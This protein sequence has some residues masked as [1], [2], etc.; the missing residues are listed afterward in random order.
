M[1]E[2]RLSAIVQT[3]RLAVF[4]PD[5]RGRLC[6]VGRAPDW[7]LALWPDVPAGG[8]V[9]HEATS[10]FLENFLVDARAGWGTP[11]GLRLRSGPWVEKDA[12]DREYSLQATSL[13]V[14]GHPT[15]LIEE[16]AAAYEERTIALQKVHEVSLAFEKLQRAEQALAEEK[17]RL[18]E[19]VE[20]RTRELSQ[21]NFALREEIAV[22]RRYADRLLGVREIYRAILAAQSPAAIAEA[23]LLRL[24]PLLPCEQ[25]S[26]VAMEPET[27][28]A[29]ILARI[30][31]GA[32]TKGEGWQ[33]S[34]AQLEG[35]RVL[36]SGRLQRISG[37]ANLFDAFT[38]EKSAAGEVWPLMIDVPL[39][40]ED[41]LVG[42]LNL[43]TRT[44]A[45]F[46]AEHEEIATEVA[47]LLAV[48][49]RQARLF[50]ALSAG[51][52]RLRALS[53][54]LVDV[55]ETERRFM[56]H[57][58]HDEIGQLLTGLK[59]TLELPG[60]E[61]SQAPDPSVRDAI[62]LVDELIGRVRRLSL[63]L[64]P[65]VLDDLGLLSA[66]DWLFKRVRGQTGIEVRF[67]HSLAPGRLPSRLE[68]AAF[69]IV[70]EAL[71]NIA[72]H[73]GVKEATVRVWVDGVNLGV[74][75]ED[76]GH[77]FD[78]DQVLGARASSG[79]AGMR[80]RALMLGGEFTLDTKPG[81]GTRLTV[82]LPL[83]LDGA[84]ARPEEGAIV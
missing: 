39:I 53:L 65:Q 45:A 8:G 33:L 38:G 69:R 71:T 7:L 14:D 72:R 40:A 37:H 17:L 56:A 47:D 22:R 57:E 59:L 35:A 80:E 46:T 43:A 67:K 23:A 78:L 20:E 19:R 5:E 34:S 77:G 50:A 9:L 64:R 2:A 31:G 3:L 42:V 48:A 63:D 36:E 58:L 15:L 83:A 60:H 74:Q 21:A 51:R 62:A 55:Q 41:T 11:G 75:V 81:K 6:L 29:T 49:L 16:I 28:Q 10:P 32:Y 84:A 73:A 44:P 52:E 24:E 79:V 70:Q 66:L 1:N 76:L 13:S 27:G 12:S 61:T 4:Q 82:E 68:T 25:A 54:R 30:Q 18:E 26:V